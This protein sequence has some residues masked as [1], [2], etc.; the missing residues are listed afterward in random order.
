MSPVQITQR[1]AHLAGPVLL[2]QIPTT[3]GPRARATFTALSQRRRSKT[4]QKDPPVAIRWTL[5]GALADHAAKYLGRGSHVNVVGHLHNHR[6][7]A[8]DGRTVHTFVFTADEI[9]FLDTKAEADARRERNTFVA[10]LDRAQAA[11]R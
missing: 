11:A 6:Y 2:D 1:H 10:E 9:D 3:D 4:D 5:W 8:E 7:T